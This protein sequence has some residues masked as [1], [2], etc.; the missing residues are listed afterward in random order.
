MQGHAYSILD[1]REVDDVR[2]RELRKPWGNTEWNGDW[3]DSSDLWTKRA[4]VR[5][6]ACQASMILMDCCCVG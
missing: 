6:A 2:L 1:V 4:R 5:P 3:S